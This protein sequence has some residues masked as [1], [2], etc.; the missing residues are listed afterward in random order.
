MNKIRYIIFLIVVLNSA[1]IFASDEFI[2]QYKQNKGFDKLSELDK[3][4]VTGKIERKKDVIFTF[5]F[6]TILPY[7][8]RMDAV[9]PISQ[10]NS[11]F[12]GVKGWV[13][14]GKLQGLPMNDEIKTDIFRFRNVVCTPF[15]EDSVNKF[16]FKFK[17]NVK[18]GNIPCKLYIVTNQSGITSDAYISE[19][20]T[21]LIRYSVIEPYQ[22][23]EILVDYYYYDYKTI[24][25]VKIPHKIE[26]FLPE[27]KST[28]YLDSAMPSPELRAFDFRKQ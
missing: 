5:N 14:S 13:R 7:L 20:D 28:I 2:T 24:E 23:F 21:N 18:V 6:F 12:D 26:I 17:E 3:W 25:G 10:D 16:S 22:G 4:H 9:G 27:D 15:Y 8:L 19:I 1:S 11:V